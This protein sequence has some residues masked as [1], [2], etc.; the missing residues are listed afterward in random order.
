MTSEQN[1]CMQEYVLDVP[2]TGW[3]LFCEV[4]TTAQ[5]KLQNVAHLIKIIA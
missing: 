5:I 4:K 3:I 1:I 2:R